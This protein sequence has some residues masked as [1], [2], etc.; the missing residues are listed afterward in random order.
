VNSAASLAAGLPVGRLS[1]RCL[2]VA[3]YAVP[4][5]LAWALAG[6]LLGLLPL[7]PVCL[8]LAI[9]YGLYYGITEVRGMRGLPAPGRRWQ[10]PQTMMIDASPSRR[11]VVWGSVL[12][13]GFLTRNPY[14]GF[15]MLPLVVAITGLAGPWAAVALGACAGLAHGGARAVA[16]LGD[17]R[18]TAPAVAGV[19]SAPSAQLDLLLK[20]VYARRLDGAVLLVIAVTA[21]AL[22]V[23]YF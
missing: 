6:G 20:A 8:G 23:S 5:V 15:G 18:V 22:A 14:A 1:V 3:A 21:A 19:P 17:L 2:V 16:L 11:V 12:G 13:P 10:V 4:A 9:L 7:A